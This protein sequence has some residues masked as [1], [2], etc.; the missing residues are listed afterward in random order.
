MKR[1]SLLRIWTHE[2]VQGGNYMYS[3]KGWAAAVREHREAIVRECV[4]VS[5]VDCW[6]VLIV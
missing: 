2:L 1:K 6:A 5:S 4:S 3:D